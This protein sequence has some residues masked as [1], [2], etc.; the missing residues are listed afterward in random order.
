M[1]KHQQLNS[2]TI[3][4]IPSHLQSAEFQMTHTSDCLIPTLSCLL[5]RNVT[6]L[7]P[8][9]VKGGNTA[10]PFEKNVGQCQGHGPRGF[11]SSF[12]R[13]TKTQ[14][15]YVFSLI[16]GIKKRTLTSDRRA[17]PTTGNWRW[18][19][20]APDFPKPSRPILPSVRLSS[21]ASS[22]CTPPRQKQ[23]DRTQNVCPVPSIRFA[24]PS[25]SFPLLL[26]PPLSLLAWLGPQLLLFCLGYFFYIF[27]GL[28]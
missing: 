25:I 27:L 10:I 9:K 18:R 2:I 20:R 4:D 16:K 28:G 13:F 26:P 1:A 3:N 6:D 14:H 23:H 15:T 8:I 19:E 7:R 21:A 12:F 24:R 22:R 11:S 5:D 17:A